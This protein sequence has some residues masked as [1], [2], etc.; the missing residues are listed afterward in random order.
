MKR[1]MHLFELFVGNMRINLSSGDIG[2]AQ[3]GL[4]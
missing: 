3:H 1:L 4:Y 2:V